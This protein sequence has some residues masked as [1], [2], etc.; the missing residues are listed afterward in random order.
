MTALST[1]S[2]SNR[3]LYSG[4]YFDPAAKGTN[5]VLQSNSLSAY[6]TVNSSWCTARSTT[7]HSSGKYVVEFSQNVSIDAI[8]AIY[9]G[10]GSLDNY[11]GA[12]TTGGGWHF[13]TSASN[14]TGITWIGPYPTSSAKSFYMMAIDLDSKKAWYAKDG[15]WVQGDPAS[16]TSPS[17]TWVTNSPLFVAVGLYSNTFEVTC[18]F[19]LTPFVG[20][21]PMGFTAGWI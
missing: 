18:N 9:D 11:P 2:K 12:A 4:S 8:Y 19:G 6:T 5:V 16:G 20:K 13:S 15:I 7:S 10:A 1:I 21:V 14:G 17:M 3:G